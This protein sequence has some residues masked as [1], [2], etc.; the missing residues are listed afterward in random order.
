[1]K[2]FIAALSIALFAGVS[3]IGMFTS[4]NVTFFEMGASDSHS[5]SCNWS[6]YAEVMPT[7][8]GHGVKEYW[9]CCH[10]SHLG[11]VF[12]KPTVGKIT[13][14]THPSDF[15]ETIDSTDERYL[16][17]YNQP[18][19]FDDGYLPSIFTANSNVKSLSVNEE[20]ELKTV[21][22]NGNFRVYLNKHY[23]DEVFSDPDIVAINFEAK[24]DYVTNNFRRYYYDT[25]I[26]SWDN[27][28][29]EANRT[30]FGINTNWKTFTYTREYYDIFQDGEA[31]ICGGNVSENNY[32][33]IDNITPVT[34]PLNYYDFEN[35]GILN[36]SFNSP[37]H[38]DSGRVH[39]EAIKDILKPSTTSSPFVSNSAAYSYDYKT[40]G[41][42]S[43]K[44]SKNDGYLA[45]YLQK[46]I[47]NILGDDL[48]L[49]DVMTVRGD[50]QINSNE[51]VQNFT[52]GNGNITLCREGKHPNNVW[53][54][55]PLDKTQ[56]TSDGRFLILQGS[57]ACD[58]YFDNF[59]IA[60]NNGYK[61]LGITP[62]A[63]GQ[64]FS[65]ETKYNV[66]QIDTLYVNGVALTPN[67]PNVT[68]S[69]KT[70]TVNP[71]LYTLGEATDV[72][73]VYR[74]G[75]KLYADTVYFQAMEFTPA[76]QISLSIAYGNK[77]YYTLK[78]HS[79]VYRITCN[80]LEVPF[81]EDGSN[82]LIPNAALVQLLNENG[83]QKTS[84]QINLYLHK[85]SGGTLL[86]ISL[87]VTSASNPRAIPNYDG[88]GI[89][90][91][92]Y[93][94][95][96]E[97]ATTKNYTNYLNPNRIADYDS[98]GYEIIYEQRWHFNKNDNKFPAQLKYLLESAEMMG[99]KVI[100]VDAALSTLAKT[101]T[102]LIGK[103]FTQMHGGSVTF[104]STTDLDNF[105][106]K[107]ISLY[108]DYP[109]LYGISLCDEPKYVHL[110]NGYTDVRQSIDRVLAKLNKEDMYVGVNLLPMSAVWS[111]A[112]Y[113]YEG[114]NYKEEP[115]Q[116]E[117]DNGVPSISKSTNAQ[118]IAKREETYR[119]YLD[120]YRTASN[121]VDYVQFD[122]YPFA[123]SKK[124]WK[125]ESK[126]LD[127]Y[128]LEN[129]LMVAS[130]AKEYDL[131]FK[132]VSQSVT[133]YG[134]RVLNRSDISWINNMLLG[135]GIKH[136][137]YF[138]YCVRG[139]SAGPDS[140]G[141]QWVDTS[142]PL[143]GEGNKTDLYYYFASQLGEINQFSKF[144]S[145]FEYEWSRLY[146]YLL[147][148]NSSLMY[149]NFSGSKYY[150]S[151]SSYGE[152]SSISTS[153]DW[154][155][156]TGL[157]SKTDSKKM[158]MI[159][160]VYNNFDS[161]LLQTVTVNFNTTYTYA[162][163]FESGLPRV[164]NLNAKKIQIKLSVGRAVF[165]L[166]Y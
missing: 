57:T 163:I 136:I 112:N 5:S 23:L 127:Y 15:V 123:D 143:N 111:N 105:V 76:S 10:H 33:V 68:V 67:D 165:M 46:D 62:L 72:K 43:A 159:Q 114:D 102:K 149:K 124:G 71:S 52:D 22:L 58:I 48:L 36:N 31:F 19:D 89:S 129:I 115:T 98:V 53:V 42:R 150:S 66:D 45:F 137:S 24:A 153:K 51:N 75:L 134:T 96:S 158:Y 142:A 113:L 154:T 7:Y 80:G 106:E 44:F 78:N 28:T 131:E 147:N 38:S 117:N 93:S 145:N 27:R 151:S 74:S 9:I 2:K 132:F 166:L 85:I 95:S 12:S 101:E 140:T 61:N 135:F 37:G 6:H 109:A 133:Y 90:T 83:V 35:G 122:I 63:T 148:Y 20:G 94:F 97:Y 82:Y 88:G 107:R 59:R 87:T 14:R 120:A 104:N 141:E 40:S 81:E 119:K 49:I 29:Y 17:P 103:T 84:G 39:Y 121:N 60:K 64:S 55:Y 144:I 65:F 73:I 86:P 164:I 160:N 152:I 70:V 26:E 11:P 13:N 108:K 92:A 69:G 161:K 155:L 47:K 138:V 100:F 54:T 91:H 116:D 4:E 157:V 8:T 16:K 30:G 3:T 77:D 41:R 118:K 18:L 50:S 125:Y 156:A 126:G 146:K 99:K 79:G 162:V 1:M 21:V 139:I 130:Y 110:V 25:L 34:Q 128:Y 56:I 32:F